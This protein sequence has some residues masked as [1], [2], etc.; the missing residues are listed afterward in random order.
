ML[1]LD[2][3][4]LHAYE[5]YEWGNCL[6]DSLGGLDGP[7][8]SAVFWLGTRTVKSQWFVLFPGRALHRKVCQLHGFSMVPS[9]S[10]REPVACLI[11]CSSGLDSW[12][13]IW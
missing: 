3:R 8:R 10:P 13:G 6:D 5:S 1:R 7:V 11:A 12:V 2:D 9:L 4:N